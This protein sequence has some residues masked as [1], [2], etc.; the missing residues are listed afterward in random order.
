MAYLEVKC[1]NINL[2]VNKKELVFINKDKK[3]SETELLNILS[4]NTKSKSFMLYI[5]QIL[6]NDLT[7]NKL[8]KFKRQN[9]STLFKDDILV[10]NLNVLE[11]IE[12]G[13]LHF[14]DTISLDEIVKS[15]SLSKKIICYPHELSKAY[16]VKVLLARALIKKP[17][18]LVCDNI[19]DDLDNRTIKK[20]INALLNYT[21]K[22]NGIVILSTSNNKLCS[23]A[24]KV[25]T[26]KNS[27]IVKIKNNKKT[28]KVGDLL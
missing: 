5:D 9:I 25:I 17:K 6:C 13:K 27:N 11:N 26:Y 19:L 28:T 2:C 10:N 23:I 16:K 8:A 1:D 7:N 21:K 4:C 14:K 22:Y 15:F 18:I 12:L 24:N 20:I 3:S